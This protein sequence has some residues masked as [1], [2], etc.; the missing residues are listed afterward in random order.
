M[1]FYLAR[2]TANEVP[3]DGFHYAEVC[4][5]IGSTLPL[6]QFKEIMVSIAEKGHLYAAED[7][8]QFVLS[9]PSHL[10]FESA[11]TESLDPS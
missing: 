11:L 1:N 9:L 8:D 10:L 4:K 3:S 2:E 5:A 6:D 7:D